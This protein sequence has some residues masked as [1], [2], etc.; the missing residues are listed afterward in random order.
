M[1]ESISQNYNFPTAG[2]QGTKIGA[3]P[4]TVS[5]GNFFDNGGSGGNYLASVNQVEVTY[6]AATAGQCLQVAFTSFSMNDTYFLCFGPNNCCDYLEIF[7]GPSSTGTLLYRNCTVSPG[8]ITSTT[9][10]LTFRFTSDGSV[11][12]GGWAATFSTV[13]CAGGQT[14]T[15][16]SD[17]VNATSMFASGI[18][19][20]TTTGLGI[21]AEGCADCFIGENYSHWYTFT[22]ATSGTLG[23][24]IDP[25]NNSTDFDF[26]L[27]PANANCG[28][29]GTPLRCSR[30]LVAGGGNTGLGNNAVDNSEGISGDQWVAPI[31]VVSGQT[32]KLLINTYSANNTG[33]T[34]TFTGT[35]DIQSATSTT[36][37]G[38]TWSNGSPNSSTDAVIASS[39]APSTFTCKSLI[40]GNGESLNITGITASINGDIINNGNGISGSGIITIANDVTISGNAVTIPSGSRINV[41]TGT[42]TT[43]GLLRIASGGAIVGNYNNINGLV[44]LEKNIIGQRGWRMFANPFSSIQTFSSIATNNGITIGTSNGVAGIADVRMF[45]NSNNQWANAGTSTTF[46]TSAK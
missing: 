3:C 5:S 1:K 25:S 13:T 16:N 21:V 40:I 37:N 28:S 35:A 31:N 8:T 45:N 29:L 14:S 36:W 9:G 19:A 23:F 32:Y 6:S 42:L 39:I 34:F 2:L 24:T 46:A 38:S 26:A 12:L 20:N 17:C 30:A 4:I 33:F 10:S 22:A 18:F 15:S 7:D 41:T 27:F 11:Q 44:T 43:G